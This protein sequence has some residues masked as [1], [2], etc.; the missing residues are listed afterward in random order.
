MTRLT[1]GRRQV[2]EPKRRGK[3][4]IIDA[5]LSSAMDRTKMS[6]RQAVHVLSAAAQSL[7]HD[8]SALV[9]N[10]ESFRKDRI[11]F[12]QQSAAEIMAAFS[13]GVPLMVPWDGKIVPAAD[14]APSEDRLPI[15]VSGDGVAKL[16]AVPKL[17][18]GTGHAVATAVLEALN[19]WKMQIRSSP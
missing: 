12:R 9:I 1:Q 11:K 15:L 7:G 4:K 8:P 16:L 18:N 13:P 2:S 5:A 19:D 3:K 6:D 10:R 14:G 17:A